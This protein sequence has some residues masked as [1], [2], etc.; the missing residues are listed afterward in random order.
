MQKSQQTKYYLSNIISQMS[1]ESQGGSGGREADFEF[2]MA[3][4]GTILNFN[5]P[6]SRRVE[7]TGFSINCP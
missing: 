6:T 1:P 4:A 7:M 5:D 2:E 3:R